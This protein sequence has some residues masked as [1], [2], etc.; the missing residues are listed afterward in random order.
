MSVAQ[1]P[2]DEAIQAQELTVSTITMADV[3]GNTDIAC[4]IAM[5]INMSTIAGLHCVCTEWKAAVQA[6][7][8]IKMARNLIMIPAIAAA[9]A[10]SLGTIGSLLPS[11]PV[12]LVEALN[13]HCVIW[14]AS[15]EPDA[16]GIQQ[17]VDVMKCSLIGRYGPACAE[18]FCHSFR[19]DWLKTQQLKQPG[20]WRRL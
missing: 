1:R 11:H 18:A 4:H 9:H 3:M 19:K 8:R 16:P 15:A 6:C 20:Q 17:A 13:R 10:S 2:D 14:H 12:G 5:Q 7:A